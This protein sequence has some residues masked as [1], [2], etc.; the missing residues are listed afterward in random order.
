ME[1]VFINN[2]IRDIKYLKNYNSI[3]LALEEFGEIG[4]LSKN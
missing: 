3:I 4:I 2:R 1:K